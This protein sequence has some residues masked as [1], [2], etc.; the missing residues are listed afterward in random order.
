M[1]RL[2]ESTKKASWLTLFF[3]TTQAKSNN[4]STNGGIALSGQ[5]CVLTKSVLLSKRLTAAACLSLIAGCA[6][7]EPEVHIV[8]VEVQVLVTCKTQEVTVPSW[9]S[10]GLKKADSLEV[11]VLLA[12]RRQR[13]GY[14]RVILKGAG[15]CS[16]GVSVEGGRQEARRWAG[17][18]G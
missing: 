8:R 12:E 9:V 11:K 2:T 15:L 1:S 7:R 10:A 13:V 6:V 17:L 5:A 4:L 18:L 16:G 3:S 14:E